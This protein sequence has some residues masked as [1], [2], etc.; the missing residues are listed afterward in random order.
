MCDLVCPA[1][2]FRIY[3]KTQALSEF[4]CGST[5]PDLHLR[6]V[7]SGASEEYKLKRETG[8]IYDKSSKKHYRNGKGEREVDELKT[9]KI[10]E[11]I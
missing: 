3:S 1:T 4:N 10:V 9:R 7:F 6:D 2:E 8:N 11:L 5:R